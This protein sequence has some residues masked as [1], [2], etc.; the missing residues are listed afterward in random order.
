MATEAARLKERKVANG[1]LHQCLC[2]CPKPPSGNADTPHKHR[3][4]LDSLT[5]LKWHG[6]NPVTSRAPIVDTSTE[7]DNA[8]SASYFVFI[9]I[10][11]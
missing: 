4:Q 8:K 3:W 9:F 11:P 7:T 6:W 10:D 1:K 5:E 2:L